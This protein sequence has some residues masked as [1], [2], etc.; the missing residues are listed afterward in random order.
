MSLNAQLKKMQ[1]LSNQLKPS[2]NGQI[3]FSHLSFID[4]IELVHSLLFCVVLFVVTNVVFSVCSLNLCWRI[5][6]SK[7]ESCFSSFSVLDDNEK[8]T[9]SFLG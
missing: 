3:I 9:K 7:A 5:S 1:N 6:L 2:R 4:M 8:V